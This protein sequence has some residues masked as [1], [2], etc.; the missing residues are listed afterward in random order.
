MLRDQ[1]TI[2]FIDISKS[3]PWVVEDLIVTSNSNFMPTPLTKDTKK[4]LIPKKEYLVALV[5]P[6]GLARLQ[7]HPGITLRDGDLL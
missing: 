2:N 5:T 1:I 4:E 7:N 3:G 6:S